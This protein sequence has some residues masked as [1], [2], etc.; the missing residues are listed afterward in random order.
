MP[1]FCFT[2]AVASSGLF[3]LSALTNTTKVCA[4]KKFLNEKE[5]YKTMK[6][7]VLYNTDAEHGFRKE[8][9]PAASTSMH[10]FNPHQSTS[11]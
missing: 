10:F 8:N 9:L 2:K 1:E 3:A 6:L 4:S 7:L 5:T 11:V